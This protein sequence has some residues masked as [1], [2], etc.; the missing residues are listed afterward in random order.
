MGCPGVFRARWVGRY[1]P[2]RVVSLR[3]PVKGSWNMGRPFSTATPLGR[4]IR[5]LGL[6]AYWVAARAQVS[7]R[8]LT[9]YLA[10][11]ATISHEHLARL[12]QVLDCEPEDLQLPEALLR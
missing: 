3:H 6:E 4:R 5:F 2:A 12:S 11:R 7:P 9:E 1:S 10:G 8:Q